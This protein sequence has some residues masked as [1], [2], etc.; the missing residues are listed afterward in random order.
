MASTIILSVSVV[1]I[2][3][4][5]SRLLLEHGGKLVCNN[6]NGKLRVSSAGTLDTAL[7][8]G[9]GIDVVLRG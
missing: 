7:V 6:Q 1:L 9:A 8:S 4:L 2:S 5:F 3:Q